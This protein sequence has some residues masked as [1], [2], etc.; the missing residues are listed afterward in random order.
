MTKGR[1]ID[2]SGNLVDEWA[3]PRP[4]FADQLG[5]TAHSMDLSATKFLAARLDATDKTVLMLTG[6]LWVAHFLLRSGL[7]FL[8]LGQ[9][10][11]L[12]TLSA[13]AIASVLGAL[14]CIALYAFLRHI[15]EHR[16]WRLL[17]TALAMSLPACLLLTAV[18]EIIFLTL[19]PYYV[20]HP[21]RWLD[22]EEL[23]AA[24]LNYQWMLFT[25]CALYVGAVTAFEVRRR[26]AQLAAARDAAQKAQLKALRLQINPHFL[27][28]TL[29]MLSGLIALGNKESSERV[30]I[31]LSRFLRHTLTHAPLQRVALADE[32]D[33]LRMYLDIESTRFSDRLRVHYEIQ[34]D[35]E[36]ALVPDLLLL[37]LAENSIKYALNNAEGGI[38]IRVGGL[39]EDNMLILY[40]ED[41]GPPP[42]DAS[43]GLGIGLGIVRQQLVALYGEAATFE[44]GPVAN[45]WRNLIRIPWQEMAL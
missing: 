39:R 12:G 16:P 23:V 15:R 38:L 41:D 27:F 14:F 24:Y 44:A 43:D 10:T 22:G 18:G 30:V 1:R 8:T 5:Q 32:I 11:D 6:C 9:T 17:L 45:G 40:L 31:K 26:D 34:P 36:R 19:S 3:P 37:P 4:Q 21:E 33:M 20:L 35:C 13:R 29:N 7:F 2:E 28:N 25:W 42:A